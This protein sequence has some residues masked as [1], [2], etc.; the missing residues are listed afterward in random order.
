MKI[1]RNRLVNYHSEDP[2]WFANPKQ[3]KNL[4]QLKPED[5]EMKSILLLH[6]TQY[7]EGTISNLG[8]NSIEL[9][10]AVVIPAAKAALLAACISCIVNAECTLLP[11]DI[12]RYTGVNFGNY[13]NRICYS[14]EFFVNTFFKPIFFSGLFLGAVYGLIH[15]FHDNQN[16]STI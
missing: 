6:G 1:R 10:S 13:L 12:H 8:Y 15:Y 2:R 11:E 4:Q 16:S 14:P 3:F 9:I 7:A 5:L